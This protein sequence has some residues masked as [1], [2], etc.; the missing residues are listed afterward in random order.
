MIS[1]LS[2][3]GIP[4]HVLHIEAFWIMCEMSETVVLMAQLSARADFQ[5][6]KNVFNEIIRN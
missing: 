5:A 1:V 2:W 6:Y 3:R 4:R